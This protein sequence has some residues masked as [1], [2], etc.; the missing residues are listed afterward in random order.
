MKKITLSIL[1]LIYS[2]LS[3]SQK[4]AIIGM[5]HVGTAPPTT[6]GFTFVALE[7]IPNGEET[8]YFTENE[9]N[10]TTN[11]FNDIIESVVAFV[12]SG[13]TKGTVVFVNETGTD[14]FTTSCCG[15]ATK[16]PAINNFALA[17]DGEA[18]F[19]YSDSDNNP[20]NGITTIHSVMYTGTT[21]PLPSN[22]GD[23]P[24]AQNPL[25]DFPTAI[26]VDGF[27]AA[28]PDRTEFVTTALARTNVTRA[29]L[30]NPS[31]YV[32]AQ[33]NV[34]LST[35]I[36]TNL[37]ISVA[38]PVSLILFEGKNE[39]NVNIL[40]WATSSET[41]NR[42]FELERSENNLIFETIYEVNGNGNSI[43][44]INY[45]FSDFD[46]K[47]GIIYYRLKQ[48]DFEGRFNYSKIISIKPKYKSGLIAYPNPAK[49]NVTITHYLKEKPTVEVFDLFG[50]KI[51][52]IIN[53]KD[54]SVITNLGSFTAGKYIIK[55][56]SSTINET[57]SIIKYQ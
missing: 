55:V 41:N 49:D 18:L 21:E 15:T 17:T 11:Q 3:F 50:N 23:I 54:E 27:P 30:E 22:G 13:I 56:A 25:V 28:Q 14:I 12:S 26:V 34:A 40:N 52:A 19:A 31:S 4:V 39:N 51:P 16:T 57:I 20:A 45:S 9:Y 48:I 35:Q 33:A 8:I 32:H 53:V 37:N 10:N 7:D 24:T 47:Q 29:I 1:L 44:E 43:E 38:L 6:D 46:F 5:N 36:F 2:A 42:K